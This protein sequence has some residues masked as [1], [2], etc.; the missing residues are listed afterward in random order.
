MGLVVEPGDGGDVGRPPPREQQAAGPVDAPGV[1][2]LVR[3][4]A[5]RGTE[6]PYEMG[7]MGL[8]QPRGLV[9]RQPLGD[10]FVEEFAQ[11][12]GEDGVATYG[13]PGGARPQM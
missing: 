9:Q 7:G 5:V 11:P 2:I 6:R 8:D 3:R 4:D 10:P 12:P 1:Q 13:R